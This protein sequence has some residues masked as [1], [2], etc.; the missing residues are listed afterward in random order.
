MVNIGDSF[1][2]SY[3]NGSVY[4]IRYG[5]NDRLQWKCLEGS[6]KGRQAEEV[7][8][9]KEIAPGIWQINWTEADGITVVQVVQPAKGLISTTIVIPGETAQKPTVLILDGKIQF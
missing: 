6:D 2:I 4:Q 5:A 1:I 9:K 7:Y 8:S 3:S